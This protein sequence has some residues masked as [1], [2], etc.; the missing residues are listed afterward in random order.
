MLFTNWR[1]E[2]EDILSQDFKHCYNANLEAIQVNRKEFVV[3]ENLD[4]EEELMQR[5]KLRAIQ[6]NE[7]EITENALTTYEPVLEYD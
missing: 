1:D 2:K 4:L 6:T 5:D 7:E 3:D